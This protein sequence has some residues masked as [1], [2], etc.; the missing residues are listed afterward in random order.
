MSNETAIKFIAFIVLTAIPG[1]FIY[2][3]LT[4]KNECETATISYAQAIKVNS[5]SPDAKAKEA[6]MQATC[7]AMGIQAEIYLKTLTSSK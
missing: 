3:M 2:N 7:K 6:E 4:A 1:M 5:L